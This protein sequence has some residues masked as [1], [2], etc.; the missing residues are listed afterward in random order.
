MEPVYNAAKQLVPWGPIPEYLKEQVT[1]M[2]A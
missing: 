2:A 1:R